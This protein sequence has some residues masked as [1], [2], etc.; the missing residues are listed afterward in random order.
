MVY[1]AWRQGIQLKVAHSVCAY[2]H[3][4]LLSVEAIHYLLQGVG[5]AVEVVRIQLHGKPSAVVAVYRLVPASAYAQ[6][7]SLWYYMHQFGRIL[8]S[9]LLQYFR[10]SIGRM[11]IYHYHVKLKRWCLLQRTF[12]GIGYGL[13]P[14]I[15]RYHH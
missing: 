10:G 9:Y 1:D 3:R 8:L 6:V 13:C 4:R 2:H 11:V 14:V 7:C 12:H 5:T 15:H